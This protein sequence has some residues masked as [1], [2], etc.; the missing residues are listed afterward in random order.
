MLTLLAYSLIGPQACRDVH[1]TPSPAVASIVVSWCRSSGSPLQM[2]LWRFEWWQKQKPPRDFGY[3]TRSRKIHPDEAAD[4]GAEDLGR[5]GW[6]TVAVL[7]DP[8]SEG[9]R[10]LLA[11]PASCFDPA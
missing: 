11:N 3:R 4:A 1:A 9:S 6:W 10:N 2:R 5:D 8:I 7:N